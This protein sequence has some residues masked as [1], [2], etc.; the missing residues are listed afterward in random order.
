MLAICRYSPTTSPPFGSLR[1]ANLSIQEE[2]LSVEIQD[3]LWKQ[4]ISVVSLHDTE[5]RIYSPYLLTPKKMEEF[6]PIMD[7]HHLYTH[8]ARLTFLH[9]HYQAAV[10]ISTAGRLVQHH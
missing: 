1:E 2:I 8:I 4:M 6:R 10:S 9:A 7:P 5:R 3:L